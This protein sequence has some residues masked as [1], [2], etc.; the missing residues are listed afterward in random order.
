MG[1]LKRAMDPLSFMAAM[2][3]DTVTLDTVS[4][5]IHCGAGSFDL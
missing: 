3:H 5:Q 2:S 4:A 1:F